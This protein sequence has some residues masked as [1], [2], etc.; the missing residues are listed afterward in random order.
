M[1]LQAIEA[2]SKDGSPVFIVDQ[3]SADMTTAHW[4]VREGVCFQREGASIAFSA[5]R[6]LPG[7]KTVE[8]LRA[9]SRVVA[10]ASVA[11]GVCGLTKARELYERAQAGG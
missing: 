6:W 10:R 3:D 5:A 9:R 8:V 4:V 11:V 7:S 2:A 1:G